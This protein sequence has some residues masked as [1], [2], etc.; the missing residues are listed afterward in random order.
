MRLNENRKDIFWNYDKYV[1]TD[2]TVDDI[3][4]IALKR[5][6]VEKGDYLIN[7]SAMPI[8]KK[9][10]VNTLRVSVID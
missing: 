9:G 3:N 6:Y 7:L 10:M 4:S 1:S 5:G 8:V 2:D